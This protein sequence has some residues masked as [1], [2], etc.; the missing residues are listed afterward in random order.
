MVSVK[1]MAKILGVSP[2][3]IYAMAEGEQIPFF[4]IGTGRGTLR[5]E[6]EEVKAAL[7]QEAAGQG[8]SEPLKRAPSRHLS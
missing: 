4:R 8:S 3:T 2:K 7:R 6:V 5:F 1:E